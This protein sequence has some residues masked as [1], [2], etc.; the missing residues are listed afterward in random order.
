M[1]NGK[2]VVGIDFDGTLAKTVGYKLE[3]LFPLKNPSVL[4]LENILFFITDTLGLGQHSSKKILDQ[5]NGNGIDKG[6]KELIQRLTLSGR[7]EFVV[8]TANEEIDLIK[9]Y[10]SKNGLNMEVLHSKKGGKNGFKFIDLVVDDS[11]REI[12]KNVFWEAEHNFA[13]GVVFRNIG[14]RVA[15]DASELEVIINKETEH[16]LSEVKRG[17]DMQISKEQVSKA[18]VKA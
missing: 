4:M 18:K 2:F 8:V 13:L 16:L 3:Y 6:L 1:R 17:T 5:V 7:F 14:L 11:F 9:D 12:K 10:L 15:S